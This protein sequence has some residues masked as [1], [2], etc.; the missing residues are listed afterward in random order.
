[1]NEVDVEAIR[2]RLQAK[3]AAGS[4]DDTMGDAEE[5]GV[6]LHLVGDAICLTEPLGF[7][8]TR[9]IGFFQITL[10]ESEQ[11]AVRRWEALRIKYEAERQARERGDA[12]LD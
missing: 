3:I 12:D 6:V 5:Y 2:E 10:F 4:Y 9:P 7:C 8:Q 11:A 1:V